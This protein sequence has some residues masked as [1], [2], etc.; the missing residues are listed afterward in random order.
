MN[1]EKFNRISNICGIVSIVLFIFML[2]YS[3]VNFQ[4]LGYAKVSSYE[5]LS[6]YILIIII[7]I[8]IFRSAITQ[9]Y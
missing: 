1:K 6:L 7:F 9:N 8:F 3:I 2:T 5:E 4:I